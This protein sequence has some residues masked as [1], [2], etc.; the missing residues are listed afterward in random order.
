MEVEVSASELRMLFG[1]RPH[2]IRKLRAP[3]LEKVK[4]PEP[5]LYAT[6]YVFVRAVPV[7]VAAFMAFFR[8]AASV[9]AVPEGPPLA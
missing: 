4:R 1:V 2:T 3:V 8:S 9:P 5:V 6:S 7:Q